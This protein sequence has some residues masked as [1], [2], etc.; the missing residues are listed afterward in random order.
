MCGIAGF[1]RRDAGRDLCPQLERMHRAIAHRGPDDRG[2]WRSPGGHALY[3]HTR[4]SV[5]DPSPAGHQPMQIEQGRFT[6]VYNGEIFNFA[7]LRESLLA[8]GVTFR[9]NSDT[10][11]LLRLYQEHGPSF[12][13]RLRGMFAF[14]IWDE[15]ERRCFLARDRFGIKPL[16]YHESGGVLAFASEV[17]ALV[18]S[19]VVDAAL[20]PQAVFE[21]F[22]SG[23]VPEPLSMIKGVRALEA[24]HHMTWADGEAT[25]TRYWHIGFPV[26]QPIADPVADT[27]AA[28]ID[29]IRHHF[30]SDVPV[31]VFLSGGMDSTAIVALATGP[32]QARL[33]T[34]SLTF[35]GSELDEGPDARRTAQHFGTDHHEW[36]VDATTARSLVG[37][38]LASADQPSIDG[39]NTFTVSRLA[40]QH[41]TKVVLSGLGGDELFGGYPS[42]REVPRLAKWGSR[43]GRT[44]G[45]GMAAA[46][47]AGEWGGAR[48]RRAHDLLTPATD[49]ANAYSVFRGIYNRRESMALTEHFA[50]TSDA[51][52]GAVSTGSMLDPTPEDTI[53][54]LELT[55]YMR[56]QLLRDT[57]VMSMRWGV[58]L[59]VPFLDAP[60]FDTLSR[61]PAPTRLAPGKALLLAAVPEIPD[62][63]ASRP[64]RGFLFPMAQWLDGA[65]A[66]EFGVPERMPPIKTDTWSRKW[67]VLAFERWA[68]ELGVKHG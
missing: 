53:S 14:A 40:R 11:V 1:V 65:W 58:E 68:R 62:W 32:Q 21:Y 23:S 24:A 7:A 44:G 52:V 35:P 43:A 16:Y 19:G 60:L 12:V 56:N 46:R 22:R 38:F 27:R 33:R 34:F 45:I 30:I 57:D 59:R 28:L 36:A 49:L 9:S 5:I 29:S 8:S 50:G 2:V 51:V 66:D 4:L 25:V 47:I 41:D 10:E 54:R 67:A 39:F 48:I 13:E 15:Q 3:A 20:E 37:E 31:G 17:R 26:D 64:K 61:I 18:T 6:I 42:F 63:V 55:R